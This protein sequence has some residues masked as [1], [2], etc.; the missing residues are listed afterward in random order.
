MGRSLAKHVPRKLV[1]VARGGDD[2]TLD[3]VAMSSPDLGVS[4]GASAI[5]TEAPPVAI[6]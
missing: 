2:M 1:Q 3:A 6:A 4:V 5:A